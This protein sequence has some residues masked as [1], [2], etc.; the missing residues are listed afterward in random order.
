MFSFRRIKRLSLLLLIIS[1]VPPT[2]IH[3]GRGGG[4]IL[5]AVPV[6]AAVPS[7]ALIPP[8]LGAAA[9]GLIAYETYKFTVELSNK[10]SLTKGLSVEEFLKQEAEKEAEKERK[11]EAYL[12]Y[13]NG[14]GNPEA[15]AILEHRRLKRA[16]EEDR[17]WA[18]AE[19]APGKPTKKDG[20]I[21]KKNWDGKKVPSRRGYGWPDEK[22]RIWVPSGE[23][24][25]GGPHWDRQ[26]PDGTYDNVV[27]GGGIRGA[28]R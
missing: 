18:A 13:Q 9:I 5:A 6:V 11:Y 16:A 25:H 12:E 8:V 14:I 19:K 1:L 17:I 23:H 3:A 15:A 10:K 24:G 20:F 21:P 4:A 2:Q 22:G 26:N 28:K 7:V 27:P